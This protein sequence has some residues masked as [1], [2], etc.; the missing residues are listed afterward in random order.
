V[1]VFDR[2]SIALGKDL[3]IMADQSLC[4]YPVDFESDDWGPEMLAGDAVFQLT[5]IEA[6]KINVSRAMDMI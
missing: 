1:F 5:E 4:E 2:N 3:R 6:Y